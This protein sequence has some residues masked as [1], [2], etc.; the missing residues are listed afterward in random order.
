MS[1]LGICVLGAGDMGRTHLGAWQTL[2]GAALVAVADI[3]PERAEAAKNDFNVGDCFTELAEALDQPGIDIASV[4]LPTHLHRTAAE[5]AMRRGVHVLCE[6]PLAMT[7]DDG[8]AMIA[9]A[10]E[11]G[12]KLALGF[13]KRFMGQTQRVRE[14]VQS[15]ALG[16][17]V[18]Y[19]VVSGVEIR[20]KPW[21]MDKQLGGG[22]LID[23]ACHYVDQWRVVFDSE[24]ARVMAMGAT[25]S[26]GAPE[27]PGID[28]EIDT[29]SVLVEFASGDMGLLSLSWGL[30]RG[31]R[32]P[33]QEDLMGRHGVIRFEGSTKLTVMKPGGEQQVFDELDRDMHPKQ[34]AAFA[35]AV[36]ENGPVAASGEDGLAALRVSLAALESIRTGQ[37]RQLPQQ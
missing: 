18:M 21:I 23:V 3:D 13:C 8:E 33:S 10:R 26:T 14:L 32:S 28:P 25:F 1:R 6:K 11:C 27:L 5:L 22:P 37:A 7:L 36:R 35:T 17:P 34:V 31:T 20:F 12:V 4:C 19:R 16:R 29:A 9:T 15:G 30:P 2:P 24:P